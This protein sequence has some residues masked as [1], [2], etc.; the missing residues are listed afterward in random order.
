MNSV[1][2]RP[3]IQLQATLIPV[4][5]D[6]VAL[7][8]ILL[9]HPILTQQLGEPSGTNALLLSVLYILACVGLWFVRKLIP[10]APSGPGQPPR[11][12]MLKWVRALLAVL[13]SLLMM[14]ALAYQLGYFEVVESVGMGFFDEG[15]SATFFVFAP[16]AWF[17]FAFFYV[18]V[19][20]FNVTPSIAPSEPRFVVQGLIGLL[21]MNG[22]LVFTVGQLAAILGRGLTPFLL[23]LLT[24]AIAFLPPRLMY[25]S[26]H[27]QLPGLIS[28]AVLLLVGSAVV[29]LL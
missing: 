19:L 14:T 11:W 3:E 23:S 5:A 4:L 28:F 24:L 18:L 1:T 16:S 17:G 29:A 2:S 27:P 12:F 13:F 21:M 26:K 6:I 9:W 20:A 10:T 7:V 22:L 25:Q 15:S 8:A